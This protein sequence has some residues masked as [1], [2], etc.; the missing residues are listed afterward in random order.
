MFEFTRCLRLALRSAFLFCVPL[1]AM[2]VAQE[3]V[4]LRED[5]TDARVFS[6]KSTFHAE[7]QMQ[8]SGGG[9]KALA[10]KLKVDAKLAYPERR[11][12]GAGRDAQALRTLRHYDQVQASILVGDQSTSQRLRDEVRLMVAHGQRE[13]VQLFSPSGPLTYGELE[14][15]RMPGDSLCLPALLP[16]DAVEAGDTWKP[17]D[18]V[19]Q[20]LTG[21]EAV[22]KSAL[23]CKLESLT[24]G[25]AR[26]S[27]QGEISGATLGAAANIKVEGYY[28]YDT[29]AKHVTHLELTQTEKRSVGSVSPG[30]D[31]VAK[32][33]LDR[34]VAVEPNRLAGADFSKLPLE[35][36]DANQLLV[37]EGAD[38]NIRFYH[39]RRWHLFHQ[40]SRV[41]VL[42]FMEKGNLIAQ[43]NINPLA[44]MEPGQHVAEDQFQAEVQQ[45]LGKNFQKIVQAEK[46]DTRDGRWI[47]RVTAVGQSQLGP[48]EWIYYAVAA[49]DGRQL[50][51][52]FIIEPQLVPALQNHDLSIVGGL[53]F[54]P[55]KKPPEPRAAGK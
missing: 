41:A 23:V 36:N 24:N 42:R 29:R 33:V 25:T 6:V 40:T 45:A 34:T 18:W 53:E 52:V 8:T 35:P 21:L 38:W 4:E 17:S 9:G 3:R 1:L 31:L 48:T 43:C 10:L 5:V 7:G 37:F 50:A 22:E 39:D 15:L 12:P 13:G 55:P 44:P 16:P 20:L 11:L 26:V 2:A 19:L 14:L 51:L 30:L 28:L 49:P 47:F 54:L 32:V 27:L 46:V